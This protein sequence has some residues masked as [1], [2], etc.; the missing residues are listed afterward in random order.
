[1]CSRT[2]GPATAPSL[3][4]WPIRIT[5]VRV[6][7]ANCR[8]REATLA[9]LR[10][11]AGPAVELGAGQGL[12]GVRD[13]H[14]GSDLRRCRQHG[15]EVGLAQDQE[16]RRRASEPIRAHPHLLF[17]LLTRH[18]EHLAPARRERHRHLEH[19]RAL[20]DAGVTAH[21][22]QRPRHESSTE[23]AVELG[24]PGRAPRSLG[25]LDARQLARRGGLASA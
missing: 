10:H 17:A 9:H 1:M 7:L 15:L 11:R 19:E 3:V 24:E 13:Q 4:T 23:H 5:T 14:G 25:H 6:P 16:S 2:R 8:Q 20:A 12:D 21:Q 22:H 18:V